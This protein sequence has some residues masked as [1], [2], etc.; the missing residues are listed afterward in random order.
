MET[1]G[2]LLHAALRAA[3]VQP[4]VTHRL[5]VQLAKH[6]SFSN[7][8]LMHVDPLSQAILHGPTAPGDPKR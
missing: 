5:L 8:T 3:S 2:E 6:D 4:V 1:S 7:V